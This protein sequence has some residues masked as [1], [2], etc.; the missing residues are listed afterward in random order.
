VAEAHAPTCQLEQRPAVFRTSRDAWGR[1]TVQ[2]H[3][4][5]LAELERLACTCHVAPGRT[6]RDLQVLGGGRA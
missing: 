1:R 3:L 5:T 6:L 4:P 2:V